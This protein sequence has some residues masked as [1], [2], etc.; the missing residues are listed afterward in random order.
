MSNL[1]DYN[2]KENDLL[3]IAKEEVE[4]PRSSV[5]SFLQ[6]SEN[7]IVWCQDDKAKLTKAGL[8][9][10]L[11]ADVPLRIGACRHAESI[12]TK[13]KNTRADAREKWK[14]LSPAAHELRD[15][16]VHDLGYA[17][18]KHPDLLRVLDEI[19]EGKSNYDMIQDLNDLAVLGKDNLQLVKDI[20]VGEEKLDRAAKLSDESAS[21][22]AQVNGD[23][24]EQNPSKLM[25]D[26]AYT[27]LSIAV[28]EI[29]ACGRYVFRKDPNRLKGYGSPYA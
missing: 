1:T 4:A 12:W 27:Y 25:R 15:D 10:S 21:L 16:L 22:Y 6:N 29:L 17:F 23:K 20:G 14:Q 8:D 19:K 28:D 7:L 5:D 3:A 18:R 13:D 11:V 26:R 2:A 24:N 9:W